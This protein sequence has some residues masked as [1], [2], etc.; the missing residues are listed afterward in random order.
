M[1]AKIKE[2]LA[3]AWFNFRCSGIF[4]T[5]PIQCSPDSDVVIVSQLHHPDM[6]M[7]MLAAKSF[8]RYI[9]PREFVIVDDGL[10]PEDRRILAKHLSA[11]R[12]VPSREVQLGVCPK[13]GCWER[14]LS[15][16]KENE[17][18]FV[19][20]LD[21]DT[22]TLGEPSEV[23]QCLA[24]KRTFTLGTSTGREIVG[25]DEASRY[26]HEKAN[27]HVQ[28]H[29]ERAFGQYPGH[30]HL[31]YVR[32]CAGFAGFAQSQL[33]RAGI[34]AFSGQM[35]TLLGKQKW[36][37]WGSEQVTSNYMAA[38]APDAVVLP[39]ERYPFWRP[40]VDI[41]AAVFVHFFGVFR[42]KEGMYTRQGTRLI[43]E[44]RSA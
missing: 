33:P 11:V 3:R 6:T 24:Q 7:Y 40:D 1:I 25:F 2:K 5:P 28:N 4:D 16:S 9:K 13:G 8:G 12:F 18:N 21:A 39:V 41:G 19:I 42:F 35:A 23:M 14:I 17:A 36:S 29:A 15:L 44:L 34:E 31:K 27:D 30:E 10:L 20:Q 22:L 26:A 37:Q 43:R 38:N 32:G